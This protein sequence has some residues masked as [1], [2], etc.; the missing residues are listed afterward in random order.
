[1][2]TAINPKGP[3]VFAPDASPTAW[4]G[5]Y[6]G[7]SV[8]SKILVALTGLGLTTFVVFHM[9]GNLKMF[10]GRESI[11]AY[12]Y[13]LK[14]DLGALIWIARAGLLGIFAVHIW[15][16]LR[17]KA[18]TAA[19]RPISYASY[20]PAQA[21]LQSRVMLTTGLVV[22]AFT[23]FH[24]AHYTFAWVHDA[25]LGGGRH[26]N[27]LDLKDDKGHHDVYSMVI[28]GFT[29]PW[30]SVLYLVAQAILLAHLTHG[31]QSS[32]QTLGLV[33][34]RFTPAAAALGY[35]VAGTIFLG[36]LAIV[37]AVWVGYLAPVYP[38]AK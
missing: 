37:V 23:L 26:I 1:M 38:M 36:N 17:L 24:L 3:R 11:N 20:R 33:G 31:V 27:Y 9:I 7:S 18:R 16:A 22:G 8:G 13:F 28:A 10:A 32:L 19:A 5:T 15:L 14:H 12:A 25:D 4:T 35:A 2:S 34:R 29:T 21:S 6:L 30:I